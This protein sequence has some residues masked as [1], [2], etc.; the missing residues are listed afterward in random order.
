MVRVNHAHY[1]AD[2]RGARY[3]LSPLG[4]RRGKLAFQNRSELHG[5]HRRLLGLDAERGGFWFPKNSCPPPQ[6]VQQPSINERHR[7]TLF[8]FFCVLQSLTA[9]KRG[10]NGLTGPRPKGLLKEK[11]GSTAPLYTKRAAQLL[12][13]PGPP[14][15]GDS[16]GKADAREASVHKAGPGRLEKKLTGLLQELLVSSPSSC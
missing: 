10:W 11:Q 8:F 3:P 7:T 14:T 12:E 15:Q 1:K 4:T 9:V 5:S 2:L 13:T 16:R 6:L